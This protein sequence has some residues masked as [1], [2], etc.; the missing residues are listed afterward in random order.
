MA[1]NLANLRA[2]WAGTRAGRRVLPAKWTRECRCDMPIAMAR[3][4]IVT[5][6]SSREIRKAGLQSR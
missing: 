5:L 3:G 1:R 2:N 6:S 4:S